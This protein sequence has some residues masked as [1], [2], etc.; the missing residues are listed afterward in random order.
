MTANFRFVPHTAKAHAHIFTPSRLG[1]RAGQRGLADTRRSNKAQDRALELAGPALDRKILDDAFLD[2][3]ETVVITLEH[4]LGIFEVALDFGLLAPRQV[5]HP[6]EII[7]NDRGFRRHRAHLL[8]LFHFRVGLLPRFLGKLGLGEPVLELLELIG[9][10]FA[11]TQF[12]LDRLHLLVEIVLALGLFHLALDP[13]AD[14]PL[15]LQHTDLA[16]HE[17]QNAFKALGNR[18]GRQNVLLVLDLDRQMAGNR[19]GELGMLFDLGD[20]CDDLGRDLLVELDVVLEL[21]DGRPRKRLGLN[22]IVPFDGQGLGLCLEIG[23]GLHIVFDLGPMQPLDQNLYGAVGQLEQLQHRRDRSDLVDAVG[24]GIVFLGIFLGNHQN[25]LVLAH[26]LFKRAHGFLA[27]NKQGH[28]HRW[29]HHDVAQRQDGV[30]LFAV[31][32]DCGC[33]GVGHGLSFRRCR[34]G[35]MVPGNL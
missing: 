7:A 24:L 32:L 34:T 35:R 1:N 30:H 13:A 27:S 25:M 2:L 26:H 8:E 5:Q 3:V 15:D 19:I 23:F 14:T 11:I 16:F 29:K 12:A 20:R 6:V 9:T 33:F 31:E 17:P 18:W 22:C 4:V 28:D 10:I 21:G